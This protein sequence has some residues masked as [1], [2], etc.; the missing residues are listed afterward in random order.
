MQ[1]PST[2]DSRM[3]VSKPHEAAGT[4]HMLPILAT[5]VHIDTEQL[6]DQKRINLIADVLY[7]RE[8]E[9]RQCGVFCTVGMS[10]ARRRNRHG[11]STLPRDI[12]GSILQMWRHV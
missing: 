4:D 7:L 10:A 3:A 8:I 2:P 1:R 11:W 9:N 5:Q 12:I 6:R